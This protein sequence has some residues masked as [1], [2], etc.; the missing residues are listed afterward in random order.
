[1]LSRVS[2]DSDIIAMLL[3]TFFSGHGFLFLFA[4]RYL[5]DRYLAAVLFRSFPCRSVCYASYV[6]LRIL[7]LCS[8]LVRSRLLAFS[9]VKN[10]RT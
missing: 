1:M 8:V 6:P 2:L 4:E 5:R 3:D 10:P 7:I 9:L